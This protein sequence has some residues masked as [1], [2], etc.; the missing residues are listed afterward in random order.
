MDNNLLVFRYIDLSI[1]RYVLDSVFN[2]I[3]SEY[4]DRVSSGNNILSA[5]WN[6]WCAM[7]YLMEEYFSVLSKS[8]RTIRTTKTYWDVIVTIKHPVME[9]KEKAVQDTVRDPVV[10]K[11]SEKDS[12]VC[13]YYRLFGKRYICVVVRHE[14]G[15]GY[16]ISAF[17][18][19]TIKK[20]KILY[21]KTKSIS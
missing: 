19:D 1:N 5:H 9:G 21:E 7:L 13:L 8:G 17:P 6:G 16:I 11:Q 20:G 12:H 4:I 2:W 3:S 10:I 14:D 18:V 15:T